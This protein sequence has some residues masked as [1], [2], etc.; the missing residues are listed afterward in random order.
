MSLRVARSIAALRRYVTAARSRGQKI[1]FVPTMGALHEGHLSLVRRARKDNACVVVSI[2]V[3]PLQFGPQEDYRRYPRTLARDRTMLADA[4]DCLFVPDARQMYG[5]EFR[6]HVEVQGWSEVW[7][8]ESRPGHFR[9]VATVVAKLFNIVQPDQAYFGHKDIQQALLI[10]RMSEDL[11]FPVKIRILPTVREPDGLAMSSR[12]AYLSHEHR[13]QA[14]V[15]SRALDEAVKTVREGN[16]SAEAVIGRVRQRLRQASEASV[17]YVGIM[18]PVTLDK[19]RMV[20]RSSILLLAVRFGNTR[21]IDN[22]VLGE[23]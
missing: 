13:Q 15:I 17:E 10:R 7:C 16:R 23:S 19:V 22:C 12:N 4:C 20:E 9:G 21:L 18:D 3:N 8:G 2:F 1:G 5:P 6:T 14:T 11:S